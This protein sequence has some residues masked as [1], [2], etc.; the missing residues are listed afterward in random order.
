LLT[1]VN[2]FPINA[3]HGS[4]RSVQANHEYVERLATTSTVRKVRERDDVCNQLPLHYDRHK[5][6]ST[7]QFQRLYFDQVVCTIASV[8]MCIQNSSQGWPAVHPHALR[9]NIAA[10]KY[11]T[12]SV[13]CGVRTD[14][15]V[16][17][18]RNLKQIG[19]DQAMSAQCIVLIGEVVVPWM[20]LLL[21]VPA[22]ILVI[23]TTCC[24]GRFIA[25]GRLLFMILR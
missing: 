11:T 24:A 9:E 13:G 14:T 12:F 7:V 23:S 3:I 2:S 15:V 25:R 20:V 16:S 17:G 18:C 5:E 8:L 6:T 22:R 21:P 1:T 4:V 10:S 19:T